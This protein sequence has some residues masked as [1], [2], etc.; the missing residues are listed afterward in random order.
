MIWLTS[1]MTG[2][3]LARSFRRSASC[4]GAPSASSVAAV[5]RLFRQQTVQCGLEL[6]GN[7]GGDT[8]PPADGGGQGGRRER[9]ERVGDGQIED[10]ANIGQ[11][12]GPRIAQKARR[13]SRHAVRQRR[14]IFV[15]CDHGPS[16][17]GRRSL[18]KLS[19]GDQAELQQNGIE[20]LSAVRRTP[21]SPLQRA[22]IAAQISQ[23]LSQG[24]NSHR[25]R[26]GNIHVRIHYNPGAFG[27]RCW[28]TR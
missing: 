1:R 26:S 13:N 21:P 24:C 12:N 5:G 4:S 15:R 10:A 3:S 8:D 23:S 9:I 16:E 19:F 2:A 22:R 28:K 6:D 25:G 14:R 27:L 7:G 18:G 17:Q 11:R 20:P